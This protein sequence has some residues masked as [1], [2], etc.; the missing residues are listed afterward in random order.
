MVY[1]FGKTLRVNLTSG[2]IE[3]E[4]LDKKSTDNY[5]GGRGLAAWLLY[6]ELASGTESLSSENKIIITTG[7]LTGTKV[8]SSNRFIIA[9]KSPQ[10]GLYLMSMCGGEFGARLRRS[11]FD[12]LILEG[13]AANPVYLRI[14]NGKAMLLPADNFWGL[15]TFE[16]ETSL[17]KK[18]GNQVGVACIGPGGENQ[19]CYSGV[20]S[21]GRTAGRGGAGAVMGYKKLKAIVVNGSRQIPIDD[22]ENFIEALR[23]SIK[24]IQSS[25]NVKNIT[26][27]GS[28]SMVNLC[29]SLGIM[30]H[31]N[32]LEA[33]RPEAEKISGEA[34]REAF[35]VKD[36]GCGTPCI[37]RCSK[38]YAAKGNYEGWISDGPEYESI[39]SLGSSCGIYDPNYIIAADRVCD[40]DGIDSI[41]AGSSIAFTME[42]FEKGILTKKDT[43]DYELSFGN[44][45]SAFELLKKIAR[46]EG[47]GAFLALGTK[48]MAEKLGRKTST[49]AMH[50]K[51]LELGAYDPRGLSA[52][53][54]VFACGPRG[55]CHHSGGFPIFAEIAG[56]KNLFGEEGKAQVVKATRD[57]RIS[58]SDSTMLCTF[59]SM[60]MTDNTI[61]RLV[62]AVTG[63][64]LD[65][66]WF[67]KLGDRVSTVE[68]SFNIREGLTRGDD[69]L[70]KRLI[71]EAVPEGP[72]KGHLINL[73]PLKDDFYKLCGWDLNSGAPLPE[74]MKDAGLY[75]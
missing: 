60:G 6:H 41:S 32:F 74:K 24:E 19:V 15:N 26:R 48:R 50:C 5:L 31:K 54:L 29:N 63:R 75:E 65:V 69:I 56:K 59:T 68:R 35:L 7:P 43:D 1:T 40:E 51:G 25:P 53:A 28:A 73:E 44:K 52:Q 37:V 64:K 18:E 36:R 72:S 34:F 17:K 27:L 11:G 70:P 33:A 39:F 22:E 4:L 49:F 30:P 38:I 2:R 20:F 58:M 46:K 10:T 16:C 14:E 62:S 71:S 61:T 12:I 23:N 67:M 47:F 42:C 3:E 8:P 66:E 13:M 45:Q 9:T 55:G 57:K 21:D